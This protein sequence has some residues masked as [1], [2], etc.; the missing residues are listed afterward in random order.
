MGM[1]SK[2]VVFQFEVEGMED[3]S[4]VEEFKAQ[5]KMVKKKVMAVRSRVARMKHQ[6]WRIQSNMKKD[7][8]R[9]E[10]ITG[11]IDRWSLIHMVLL[12]SVGVI[13]VLIMRRLFNAPLP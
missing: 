13:Q 9:A 7:I 1:E 12:V 2:R 10:A 6:Q 11:M 8:D 3:S 5:S 4:P